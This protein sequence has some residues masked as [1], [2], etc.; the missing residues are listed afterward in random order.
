M[1]KFVCVCLLLLL[2]L[3]LIGNIVPQIEGPTSTNPHSLSFETLSWNGVTARDFATDGTYLYAG[4]LNGSILR[5]TDGISWN[6]LSSWYHP[7]GVY[8]LRVDSRG[9]LFVGAASLY[10]PIYRSTD[11][12]NSFHVVLNQSTNWN[13]MLLWNMAEDSN[14]NLYLASYG[15]KAIVFKSTSG[16]AYGSWAIKLNATQTYNA[17]HMHSIY[18][19]KDINYVY[20]SYGDVVRG[21]IRSIDGGDTWTTLPVSEGVTAITKFKGYRYFGEDC[22]PNVITRTNDDV[23]FEVAFDPPAVFYS[24]SVNAFFTFWLTES[25]NGIMYAGTYKPPT[26]WATHNGLKWVKLFNLTSYGADKA[27]RRIEYFK[28]WIYVSGHNFSFRFRPL[29]ETNLKYVLFHNNTLNEMTNQVAASEYIYTGS[30]R[31]INLNHVVENATV[32]VKA[33][34]SNNTVYNSGFESW[35]GSMP[36]Y[37]QKS[38]SEITVSQSTDRVEGSYSVEINVTSTTPVFMGDTP[39]GNDWV[40]VTPQRYYVVSV[41]VKSLS[42]NFRP[43]LALDRWDT[44]GGY[45]PTIQRIAWEPSDGTWHR[46]SW[47]IYT[48][49]WYNGQLRGIKYLRYKILAAMMAGQSWVSWR[50]DG[51]MIQLAEAPTSEMNQFHKDNPQKTLPQNSTINVHARTQ[52]LLTPYVPFGTY[53]T[54]NITFKLNGQQYSFTNVANGTERTVTTYSSF[55]KTM[56]FTEIT[57]TSGIALIT[58]TGTRR[59]TL[60]PYSCAYLTD[61]K[62]QKESMQLTINAPSG[63][64]STT[65][66]YA[67]D[68][69]KPISVTGASNWTYDDST[70]IVTVNLQHVNS[71]EVVLDWA[72]PPVPEFPFASALELGLIFVIIYIWRKKKTAFST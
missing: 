70:K 16:G 43:L 60:T 11:N 42:K 27:V 53:A 48:Q 23:N 25:I 34:Y 31:M 28:K 37:W 65:K 4:L 58:L 66:V 8:A 17:Y 19:D 59:V 2:T 56:N 63:I 30:H 62:L 61:Y 45:V 52:R 72:T 10:Y 21:D 71:Q 47:T 33:V 68:K 12:G 5:T 54:S 13:Y 22:S 51:F 40:V 32:K 39:L 18:V 24:G 46:I 20:A 64:T 26:I 14:G 3:I 41:W 49:A 9:Y 29:N 55:Y 57:I 15:E 69:G 38:A 1:K 50:M 67:G 44:A 7:S 36:D 6:V 35:T